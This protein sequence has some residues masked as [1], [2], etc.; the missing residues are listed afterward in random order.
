MP[1][2]SKSE[3]QT[4]KGLLKFID[5]CTLIEG[6]REIFEDEVY[7][8][9][10]TSNNP[11]IIDCGANIGIASIY[12]KHLYPNARLLSFEPDPD[13]FSCLTHNIKSLANDENVTAE[14]AAVWI[15]SEGVSFDVEGGFSGQISNHGHGSVKETIL[16]PSIRLKDVI[17]SNSVIDLL[18]IDI[19]GAELEVIEDIADV[20]GHINHIFIEYHSHEKE[21]Q[22]LDRILKILSD[23]SFRYHITDAYTR[24][25]P[26]VSR[27]T[28]LG[29]DL[30]LN[31]FGYRS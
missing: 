11:F 13:A 30:Q 26:F 9:I 12:F 17:I 18:K 29:M 19:E 16:V 4:S 2:Y 1:R 21:P 27:E 3:I 23:N 28:M 25:N 31:I 22:K 24:S 10:S 7:R 20:L 8:F 14:Q 6:S 15:H 5:S